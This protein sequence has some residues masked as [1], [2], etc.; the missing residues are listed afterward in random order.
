MAA[1]ANANALGQL[2]NPANANA[3]ANAMGQIGNSPDANA[4]ALGQAAS[5]PQ[6]IDEFHAQR[7]GKWFKDRGYS[8][9]NDKFDFGG[10]LGSGIDPEAAI[11]RWAGQ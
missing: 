5:A 6:S 3:L 1:N 11:R 8:P 4:N 2:G 9:S 10:L 7:A